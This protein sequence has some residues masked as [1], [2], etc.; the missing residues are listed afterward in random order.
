MD[1]KDDCQWD[2][3][4]PSENLVNA[5]EVVSGVCVCVCVCVSVCVCVYMRVRVCLHVHVRVCVCL[6]VHVRVCVSMYMCV[7][8]FNMPRPMLCVREKERES[9]CVCVFR[10]I[11]ASMLCVRENEG[12]REK[13]WESKSS[14]V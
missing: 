6:H 7:S 10:G 9:V 1:E 8:T 13:T 3:V 14:E 5:T 11:I 12:K 2:V 4:N